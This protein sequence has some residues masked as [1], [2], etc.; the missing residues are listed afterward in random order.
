MKATIKNK[1]IPLH[2]L[3]AIRD[4]IDWQ[5]YWNSVELISFP[6]IIWEILLKIQESKAK[7]IFLISE[8]RA[9]FLAGFLAGLYA[10]V[11]VVLPPSDAPNFLKKLMLEGDILLTDHLEDYAELPCLS[12]KFSC[13]ASM[14]IKFKPLDPKKAHIIFY[15]S[16]SSGE[17][18]AVEKY[19]EQLEAE[20]EKLEQLY[21]VPKST[22]FLS[23]VSHHH[24]YA[25]LYS[26]LW[27]VCAGC[28]IERFTFTYWGDVIKKGRAG[29]VL[30]SSPAHLGRFSFLEDCKPIAF[31][32]VFSSGAMLSYEAAKESKKHLGVWP[33][34]V[35][36]STE[37]GGIAFRQQETASAPW[38]RFDCVSISVDQ[39]FKLK[40]KS[41]YLF[42]GEEYQTQDQISW[43]DSESFHLLGR[44]DR[45]V[46]VE[47]K[48]AS[49]IEIELKL[50]ESEFVADASVIFLEKSYREEL[51][52]VIVLSERGK[53]VL[54][55]I[56]KSGIGRK[57]RNFLA[58]YFHAV[59]IPRKWRFVEAI[60]VNPQGKRSY[61]T[62]RNYFNKAEST[63]LGP[64]LHP[65]I[66]KKEQLKSNNIIYFLRVPS[67]L[68]YFEGHF[69]E[70]PV[71]PGVVQLNWAVEFAKEN[72]V[73]QGFVSQAAQIK[74]TSL[75]TPNVEVELELEYSPDK[76]CVTFSYRGK[77]QTYSS[78]RLIFNNR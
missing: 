48:R 17:P 31:K 32:R 57:L 20:V 11:S 78:G 39:D 9:H 16:G 75:L 26:L 65:I 45:I 76:S 35:Y 18:K 25:L 23:T 41:P 60:P 73:L 54:E 6:Q 4:T 29:D 59:V 68:A 63:A 15:T 77:E 37:T 40:V 30:I 67:D 38:K 21:A 24:L 72:F 49:L 56:G 70:K 8:D 62:L 33:L 7:R 12:L 19:L 36:G 52:A 69:K 22:K 44:A 66:L 10:E 13:K 53:E 2:Q 71:V 46:K 34:E 58:L 55:A 14:P 5:S 61:L 43:V 3:L 64:I 42:R 74:F 1:L 47:G 28:Q 27:P 50:C 51:G